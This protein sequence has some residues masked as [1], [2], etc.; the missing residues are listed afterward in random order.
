M[1]LSYDLNIPI[2]GL[3]AM[4]LKLPQISA[5]TGA[6]IDGT[7]I[8]A[9][10]LDYLFG[11]HHTLQSLIFGWRGSSLSAH[12]TSFLEISPHIVF[13]KVV[14]FYPNVIELSLI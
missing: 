7:G 11:S 6:T 13:E 9:D 10:Q 1:R 2:A 12:I 8:E 3:Q 4:H 5:S 14:R